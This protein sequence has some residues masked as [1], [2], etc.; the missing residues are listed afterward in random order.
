M[1][2]KS[3]RRQNLLADFDKMAGE[4]SI[5]VSIAKM[6]LAQKKRYV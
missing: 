6:K 1:Y 4:E 2:Q 5:Q 3:Y